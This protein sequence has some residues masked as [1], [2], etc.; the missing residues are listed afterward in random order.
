MD[1]SAFSIVNLIDTS[2]KASQQY[3]SDSHYTVKSGQPNNLTVPNRTDEVPKPAG[4]DITA[5]VESLSFPNLNNVPPIRADGV[6]HHDDLLNRLY[7]E[8]RDTFW[9]ALQIKHEALMNQVRCQLTPKQNGLADA[10]FRH[11]LPHADPTAPLEVRN[12]WSPTHLLYSTDRSDG[13]NIQNNGFGEKNPAIFTENQNKPQSK[14]LVLASGAPSQLVSPTDLFRSWRDQALMQTQP[15]KAQHPCNDS[16]LFQFLPGSKCYP[17]LS[18]LSR[19]KRTR[20]AFS[21]A[22]VFELER[23][24]TYQRYLSAPERAELARSLRLS[25]TQVKIWF[26]NRRYKTKKRQLSSSCESPPPEELAPHSRSTASPNGSN[27]SNKEEVVETLPELNTSIIQ[28]KRDEDHFVA[29]GHPVNKSTLDGTKLPGSEATM[30][31]QLTNCAYLIPSLA[32]P[33]YCTGGLPREAAVKLPHCSQ[34]NSMKS[35][36]HMLSFDLNA[37]PDLLQAY[38]RSAHS[39]TDPNDFTQFSPVKKTVSTFNT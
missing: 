9:R 26:Q 27:A 1:G 19:K 36:I 14:G 2:Q 23:R 20:A 12:D 33:T 25:E 13:K 11:A 6:S 30:A 18:S 21:H 38:L 5:N 15:V 39:Q 16:P 3:N 29:A 34:P 8:Y 37:F 17:A 4:F 35:R 22:Q 31:Y 28:E 7:K 10:Y 32:N 24:F